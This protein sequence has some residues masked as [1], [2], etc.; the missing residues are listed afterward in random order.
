MTLRDAF[1][2]FGAVATNLRWS[3]SAHTPDESVVVLTWWKDEV[4]EDVGRLI[5]D[6]RNHIRLDRWQGKPGN[7][8]RI[9]NLVMARIHCDG[10]FRVVWCE[11]RDTNEEPRRTKRRWPDDDLWMQLTDL[12][13]ETGEFRAEEVQA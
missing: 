4:Q 8:D 2:H 1:G 9:K 7:R 12:N 11:A 3:W 5:Y 13:E 10:R 6:M